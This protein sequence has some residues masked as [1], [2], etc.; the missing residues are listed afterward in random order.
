MLSWIWHS[1]FALIGLSGLAVAGL[2]VL[3]WFVPP[4]RRLALEAAAIIFAAGA[5]YAKGAKDR[6]DLETKRKEEAVRK[7][8][9]AYDKI[10][11]RPDTTD[12]V[13]KRLRNDDF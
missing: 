1:T 10:D 8:Q 2:L 9:E 12:D 7:A 6:A 11:K 3:A 4:V 13:T 5:I